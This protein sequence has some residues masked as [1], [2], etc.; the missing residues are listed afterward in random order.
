MNLTEVW[1]AYMATL[2]ERAPVTAAAIRP[3]RTSDE[4]EAAERE[5]TPWTSELREFYGLHDGQHETYGEEYVPVG[6]VL[7]DFTLCSLD[8][9]VDRH[10]FSL[11]NLHPIDD[12]GEDW[13]AEVLAQE[14]GE[15][16]EMFVPAYVPIAEDGSG[17]TLY[18][19]TRPGA[20]QGC[21][22]NFSSDSAD[23]GAPWFDSLTEYIAAVHRSVETGSAIYDDVRPTFVEGVLHWR[24]PALSEGSMAYAATL[25]VVRVP[26]PLIDFRP[27]QLSDDDDLIDLD[28]VRRTVIETARRLHP[29][30]VV[31]D[32]RAVYRQVPRVRGAN[33]NWWVSMD[34]SEVV[35]TA[36]VTGED[37]DVIVLELPSGGC[38]F[39]VD[40]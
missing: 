30:S 31:E 17:S 27:S 18:V 23:Q 11:E 21:V 34:G 29:H 16:A 6:S 32:A 20:R 14:A 19:D 40:E 3:P 38:V 15:T 12:L 8:R 5:T 26:F 37:H 4:R 25:P 7:P 24:D 36:I 10:R 35:F 28:H 33:M 22:R 9:A 13:P 1:A 39:E 2:R